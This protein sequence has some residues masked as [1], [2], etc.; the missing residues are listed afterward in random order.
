MLKIVDYQRSGYPASGARKVIAG[1]PAWSSTKAFGGKARRRE[2]T[3]TSAP[4]E[5]LAYK[6]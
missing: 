3:G 1:S 6:D 5:A 2:G 4:L